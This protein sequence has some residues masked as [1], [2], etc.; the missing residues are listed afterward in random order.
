MGPKETDNFGS[1]GA[2]DYLDVLA[3]K[4]VATVQE[5]F[6]DPER[7]EPD[8]DG[9]AMLMP[10]VELLALLCERYNVAPPK[11]S[12]VEQWRNGYLNS[13]D[14]TSEKLFADEAIREERRKVIERTFGWLSGL[15]E[16][17]WASA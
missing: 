3:A 4:L 17:F 16:S 14:Q 8:E 12:T 1:Q 9:E 11:P 6:I 5:I 13:Y 7:I 10:S 15:S 2:R